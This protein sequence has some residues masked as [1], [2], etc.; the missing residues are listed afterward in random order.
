MIWKKTIDAR[1]LWEK[2]ENF[3]P[4]EF[5]RELYKILS[6]I[7]FLPSSLKKHIEDLDF[8]T[9]DDYDEFD[10]WLDGFYDICDD[11]RIWFQTI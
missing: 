7:E 8:C 11:N 10:V 2:Y 1:D 9:F 6:K 3:T 4:Q 5:A